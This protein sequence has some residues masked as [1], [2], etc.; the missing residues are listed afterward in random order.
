M[1][2]GTGRRLANNPYFYAELRSA[3]SVVV[4]RRSPA[5]FPGLAELNE[6]FSDVQRATARLARERHALL[7]DLRNGPHRSDPGVE[8][9]IGRHRKQLLAGWRKVGFV[10]G[11]SVGAIQIQRHM[12]QDGIDAAVGQDDEAVFDELTKAL[13]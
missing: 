12:R 13:R 9:A 8:S 3:V 2:A 11:T 5:P 7:I 6:A 1:L 10:V 4:L